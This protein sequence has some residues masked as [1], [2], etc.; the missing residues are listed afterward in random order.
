LEFQV[1]G[2][3]ALPTLILQYQIREN[4]IFSLV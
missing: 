2:D 4:K 1:A 3:G